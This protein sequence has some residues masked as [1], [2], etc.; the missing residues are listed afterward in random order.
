MVKR[1]LRAAHNVNDGKDVANG[2]DQALRSCKEQPAFRV[3]SEA[4]GEGRLERMFFIA[5]E[6][7]RK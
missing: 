1:L 2:A 5:R 3:F 4:L 6:P 7:E